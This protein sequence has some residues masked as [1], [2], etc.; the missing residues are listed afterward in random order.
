MRRGPDKG[1][2]Q[3]GSHSTPNMQRNYC[4]LFPLTFSNSI[5]SSSGK[6][7]QLKRYFVVTS[8]YLH[9]VMY[10]LSYPVHILA[11]IS[12]FSLIYT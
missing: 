10:H 11:S 6:R 4:L 9:H 5:V 7:I 3:G 12:F 8:L 2:V 1:G